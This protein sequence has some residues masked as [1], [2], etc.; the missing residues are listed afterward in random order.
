MPLRE[1]LLVPIAGDNPSG[2][3]LKYDKIFDQ[4]KEARIEDDESI[5]QGSWGRAPKKADRVLVLKVAGD[6]LATRSKDLRLLSWYLE[7]LVR[8]EGFSQLVGSIEILHKMQEEFW[9]T[10]NP[11]LDE[12][13]TADMRIGAVELA[14]VLLGD[15]LKFIPLTRSGFNIQQYK[16]AT[17]TG[18]DEVERSYEQKAE[19]DEAIARGAVSADELK[20]AVDSTSKTFYVDLQAVLS[21]ALETLDELSRF[22]EDKYGDDYPSMGRLQKPIQEVNQIV[23]EIL[24]KKRE[25]DPDIAEPE[26][27]AE[28]PQE[29]SYAEEV[30]DSGGYEEEAP[31]AK[32]APKK[33]VPAGVPTDEKSAYEQI[34]AA[35]EFLRSL[36][37]ASPVPYLICSALGLG[38][39]RGEGLN[40]SSFPVAPPTETRQ[41]LRRLANESN[42]DEL[43]QLCLKTMAEPCG[44]V[45]LDLQ[46][47]A[48][49]AASESWRPNL[50]QAI[51]GTVRSLLTDVPQ[52]RTMMM[53]DDTPAANAETLQWI[54][55]EILPPPP[56]PEQAYVP[57]PEPEAAY[58]APAYTSEARTED[59]PPDI[60]EA[61][62]GVL[63]RG[64]VSEAI[65]M[66]VRD[67]ELQPSG[68]MR[69]QRRVQMAQ[70]CLMAD[71]GSVAY[72]VLR[73]LSSEIERR[74]LDTW[75][76]AEL[77]S[78][79]LSLLLQCLGQRNA[80]EQDKEIIFERLCRLDPQAA[81]TVRR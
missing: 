64:R 19:R 66:L 74:A 21:Q 76:S 48:W 10:L 18:F 4:L 51:A 78:L 60:Y 2:P 1:D 8:R 34:A 67:S 71:Q 22:Q 35:A 53:D 46:R 41:A 61:A 58:Q 28:E 13:G 36:N 56:E 47:Y 24:A 68:R 40:D 59:A 44:R 63:K 20:K 43:G 14:A 33:R 65:S 26:P 57:E 49:R 23:G 12:D 5:P 9:E 80:S 27:E 73:D 38:D 52:I 3:D 75:E 79:P 42:W 39:A 7:S 31:A 62:V 45:W 25:T 17:A 69:F 77:L 50:A 70:L 72:P 16:D 30:E 32:V 15:S 81:L 55:S 37:P 54:D 6:A 11:V 29:S